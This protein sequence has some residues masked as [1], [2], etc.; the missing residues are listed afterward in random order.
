MVKSGG[1]VQ[2]ISGHPA[3]ARVHISVISGVGSDLFA[4]H[5]KFA[6]LT[7][8][9]ETTLPTNEQVANQDYAE[10]NAMRVW[11]PVRRLCDVDGTAHANDRVMSTSLR[12][13]A[14][15]SRR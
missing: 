3:D 13:I 7:P 5:G 9:E 11:A 10:F 12:R 8:E 6:W 2:W 4:R 14:R 15:S 1:V